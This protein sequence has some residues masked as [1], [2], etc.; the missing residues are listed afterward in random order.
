MSFKWQEA[1]SQTNDRT[2]TARCVAGCNARQQ[3]ARAGGVT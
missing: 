1:K 3:A 2:A